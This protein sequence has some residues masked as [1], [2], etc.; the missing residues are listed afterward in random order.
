MSS[1]NQYIIIKVRIKYQRMYAIQV[2]VF[3]LMESFSDNIII[4]CGN[5][6]YFSKH[7]TNEHTH[8]FQHSA[9]TDEV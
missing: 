4:Y 5:S 3:S 1:I 9:L 2:C 7:H 8:T 6:E